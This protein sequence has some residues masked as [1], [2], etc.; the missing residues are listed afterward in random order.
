MPHTPA[1]PATPPEKSVREML[2]EIA[3]KNLV[4]AA[5]ETFRVIDKHANEA[6]RQLQRA[7][8]EGTEDIIDTAARAIKRKAVELATGRKQDQ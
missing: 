1:V 7:G 2:Q 6:K 5:V 3:N 4:T 8:I